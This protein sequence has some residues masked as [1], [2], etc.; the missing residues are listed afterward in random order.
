MIPAALIAE[1]GEFEQPH[2]QYRVLE[3]NDLV[4]QGWE[5]PLVPEP[6]DEVGITSVDKASVVP[7]INQQL[8]ALPG[9]MKPVA[10]EG[11]QVAEVKDSLPIIPLPGLPLTK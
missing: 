4:P 7:A 1:A 5:P 6:Y 10:F 2:N 9:F 11:N 8:V 3:W